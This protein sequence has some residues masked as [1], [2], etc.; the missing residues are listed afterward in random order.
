MNS[1]PTF[2]PM[3]SVS[4]VCEFKYG[5]SLPSV[6]RSGGPVAV[7]GSNGIVGHHDKSLTSGPAIVVGR[8]GS[9]GQVSYS[10]NPCWP[11]DTTYYI[12]A[13]CTDA[14]LRW[15]SYRLAGLGLTRLNRAAAIP[16]LNRDD[17]Y[18][19]KFLLPPLPEQRRIAT[20]LDRTEGLRAKRHDATARLDE[21]SQ[22]IFLDMFGDPLINPRNLDVSKLGVVST[23]I[24]KGESPTWQG[25]DYQNDGALFVTSENVRLGEIDIRFPKYVPVEFHRKLHRSALKKGDILVNLVGA[26]IGRSC[27]FQGWDGPANVNQAVAVV[28]LDLT[29]VEIEFIA[30]FLNSQ[31]GQEIL[32]GNRVEGA[33]ANISL[34]DLRELDI[35]LPPLD[36]QSQFTRRVETVE[37]LK[38]AHRAHLAELESLFGSLQYRAFRG[39]L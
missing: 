15:L 33:R 17:A 24:T 38:V 3:V 37:R 16:G 27:V 18:R 39:E 11:I 19:L 21:L 2:W 12:D 36:L 28:T 23:R 30:R 5:K 6:Q 20:E 29:K 4:E 32:L 22:S 31:R 13:T 1:R 25:F 26:S 35:L 9:F 14:D 34:T 10:G 7:F 8:K